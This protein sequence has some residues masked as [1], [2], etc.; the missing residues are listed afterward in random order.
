MTKRTIIL[1]SFTL[2]L[3]AAALQAQ[4][5]TATVY[6]VVRDATGAVMPGASVTATNQG[7]NLS[8]ETISDERGEF[9]LPAL[10]TGR[11]ALKIELQGFKT[12][13]N[14]GL[15]LAAGQTV[16][17]TYVLEI[18]Q[19][20]E[21][22]TV[23]ESAP[24]V[25]TTSAVQ[26]ESIGILEV[27]QLPV[28]RRNLVN[29]LTLAPGVTEN[30]TGIAGGG[31]I[32]LNGVAEGGTAITVDG[33]DA[34]S[35]S[36]TR[37]TG[38]YGGQNQISVMSIEAIAEVQIVKGILPAE[39][40]G[41]AGGQVNMLS[42]SG[43]NQFHGSAFENYQN[44]KFFSRDPFLASTAAKPKI[45][46]NQFGGSLGGPIVRDRAMFFVAYEGYRESAGQSVQGNVPT[47]QTRDR[48]LA[49]LPFP[50]TKIALD[51]L[52]MPNETILNTNGAVNTDIGRYRATGD[53]ERRDNHITAKGDIV[54][55]NGNLS[56]TYTRMRPYTIN[57]SIYVANNQ[58]F[59][60]KQDRIATQYVLAKGAWVSES[61]VGWNR[62]FLDRVHDFWFVLDPNNAAETPKATVGRR[63]PLMNISN[64]F[65]T[66][67]AEILELKGK[68][69]TADQKISHIA[70]GH[71]IKAGFR[72]AR[73]GGS[74]TNPQNPSLTFSNLADAL[75][76]TLNSVLLQ[77]GKPP[78]DGHLDEFS[79]FIQDD[80]RLNRR[81]VVNLG[82]RYDSY[83][84][85]RIRPTT[86]TPAEIVNLEPPSDLRKLD[87]GEFRDP[88]KPYDPDR[89][90]FGPRAGFAYTINESGNTVV[91]GGVGVL[92]SP[93][94]FATLQ[95]TVSDPFGPADVQWNRTEIAVK[96][97]RWPAYGEDLRN[98]YLRDAAG[99]KFLFSII[100]TKLPNPYTVQSMISFE[101]AIGSTFMVEANYIRTDG[102]NFPLHRPF[103]QAFDRATGVR[104][105]PALGTI[106]GYHISSEQ[107]M[108]YNALQTSLR[109]RFANNLGFD[110]HYTLRK[111]WAEQGAGL[112]SNF[113]NSDI[114]LT[115][116]FWDP[117][118]DRSAL[119]QEARHNVSG[120]AIYELPWLQQGRGALSQILGGWQ[121]SSIVSIR[122]GTPLRVTQP[123]GISQSRPDLLNADE[124]VLSNWE[125]TLLYL[126][127][128]AFAPVPTYPT[129]TATTRPGTANPYLLRGPGRV[130]I[131]LSLGKT[132]RLTE[133][134]AV[135]VRADA[136]NAFNNVNYN[137]PTVNLTSPDFGKITG[138]SV[139]GGLGNRVGQ[140]GARLTF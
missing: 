31:N 126:N 3:S 72:W 76:N 55:F 37:G 25:E 77:T 93:H 20:S 47:Q 12:Y 105:N 78:H 122:S 110:I 97:I 56:A 111:G 36:E 23:A 28:A 112:S 30:S 81:L 50:E 116:D 59:F 7:T 100:D 90:N 133:S 26:Q 33:T 62:S 21:N 63:M 29:L 115:Q 120:N 49:A 117:G 66:V 85:I 65:S 61:R 136:F 39:Y 46:F 139:Q 95:N 44:D 70:G 135:Q 38:T 124:A 4:V 10:P 108:V 134:V 80:W 92:Y 127:R 45:R 129:T 131:D 42:R 52:P 118:F 69:W 11:Y 16:R 24:L 64:L 88:D 5:T 121:I 71:N 137:N 102:K 106:S 2:L 132:F 99:R 53:R 138:A 40:G 1:V 104:P 128:A 41:A 22:I 83:S 84:T 103:A 32:R 27:S 109:R 119:S 86:S 125:D 8:R 101:Q 13:T 73:Q 79:V 130:N 82:L 123:S 87:F 43:T 91:R 140:I 113:V 107:T 60:N 114:F 18:G 19:L 6:G 35:N 96:G 57:P 75:S 34:V 15:D 58:K 51:Q 74:K 17:Q 89:V 68:S 94:L 54:V 67:S 98:L 14:Q 9:A 48:L